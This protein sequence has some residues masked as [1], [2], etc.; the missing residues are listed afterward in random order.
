MN[1]TLTLNQ[2][3]ITV[4]IHALVKNIYELGPFFDFNLRKPESS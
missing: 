4:N 3:V 1:I 2:K